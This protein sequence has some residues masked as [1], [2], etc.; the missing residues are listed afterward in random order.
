MVIYFAYGILE[1]FLPVY[2][3]N[4]GYQ[5]SIIGLIFSVQII[6]LAISKPVFG[7]L[8]DTIDKRLQIVTG[9]ILF[10]VSSIVIVSVTNLWLI[11]SVSII[12]GLGMS[13]ATSATSIYVADLASKE[14]LGGSMGALSSIMDLGQSSGPLISGLIITGTSSILIGFSS[15]PILCLL[16]VI[17]FVIS[18]FTHYKKYN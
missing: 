11:I 9:V 15:I 4:I 17:F 2:L 12:F 8:A 6:T 16:I 13:I 5:A 18:N 14:H 1:T 3:K 10:A 7:R